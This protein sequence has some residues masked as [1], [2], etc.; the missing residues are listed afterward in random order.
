MV[1]DDESKKSSESTGDDD[2]DVVVAVAVA[3]ASLP[4]TALRRHVSRDF[5][6]P[7][8]DGSLVVAM[9]DLSCF[10]FLF[11]PLSSLPSFSLSLSLSFSRNL[12][13][14]FLLSVVFSPSILD[15]RSSFQLDPPAGRAAF[16]SVP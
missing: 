7:F 2:A 12:S 1:L 10:C 16:S 6:G 5:G 14:F 8:Q 9:Q 4:V 11:F 13:I 15:A 3:T